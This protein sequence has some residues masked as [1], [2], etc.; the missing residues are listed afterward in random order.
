MNKIVEIFDIHNINYEI[1]DIEFN[2]DKT[3]KDKKGQV[4]LMSYDAYLQTKSNDD[5]L[6]L[7]K[8]K[9]DLIVDKI[10]L[11]A[12]K[13]NQ[14]IKIGT[15]IFKIIKKGKECYQGCSLSK[16]KCL[17]RTQVFFCDIIQSGIVKKY[18]FI[19]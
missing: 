1:K 13:I 8:F 5:G 10:V 12:L 17:L 6:C 19:L 4:S 16:D 15:A 3:I 9:A 7:K 2:K 18:D 11:D 14:E